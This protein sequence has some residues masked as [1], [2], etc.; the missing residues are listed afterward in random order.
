MPVVINEV[1]WAGNSTT[2]SADEWIELYN[3]TNLP[4][5][6]NNFILYSKTDLTPYVN[7]SGQIVSNGYYLLERTNND[8]ISNIAADKIYTGDLVNFGENIALVY[9]PTGQSHH[10]H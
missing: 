2:Y 3:R 4:V 8:T 5:N 1:A 9:K 7:L 10:H 6:L